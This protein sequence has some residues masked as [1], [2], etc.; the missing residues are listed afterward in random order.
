MPPVVIARATV[1]TTVAHRGA[2]LYGFQS[3]AFYD[4]DGCPPQE[5]GG[6]GGLAILSRGGWRGQSIAV[7]QSI[8]PVGL[9]FPPRECESLLGES[10]S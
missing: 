4:G 2:M 3:P 8:E 7:E 6:T 5:S 9:A 10:V 1:V